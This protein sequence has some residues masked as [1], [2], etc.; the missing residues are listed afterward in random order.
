MPY[1]KLNDARRHGVLRVFMT[2]H[3]TP[4]WIILEIEGKILQF[5]GKGNR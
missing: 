4:R 5:V 2:H 3:F 1:G